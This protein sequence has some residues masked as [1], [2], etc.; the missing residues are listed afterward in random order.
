MHSGL[1]KQK[2]KE[3]KM[4]NIIGEPPHDFLC[5]KIESIKKM[6]SK[7]FESSKYFLK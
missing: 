1:S 2:N 3:I 5:D 6:Y 4:P 7:T